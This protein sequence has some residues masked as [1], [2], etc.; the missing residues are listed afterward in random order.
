MELP[1]NTTI[2]ADMLKGAGRFT[3]RV[4]DWAT[5]RRW[6]DEAFDALERAGYR[7]GSAYTVVKD[8]ARTTFVYRDRLW[9]GADLAAIGVAS[10]GY[11]NGVHMQNVDSWDAYLSALDRGALP[12][13]RAYRPT[14]EERL[15]RELVLQLKR[16]S[17]RTDYFA[18]KYGVDVR[19][20]FAPAWASLEAEG[21]L[22]ATPN[23]RVS[24][25][26]AGLLRVDALL[27]RFFL[28]EHVGVRYT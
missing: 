16:G 24:L 3:E 19:T 26:R 20:R 5:R 21:Y 8:P 14:A 4:A 13:G 22:T 15:I 6:V 27:P 9:Q 1:Y 7:I 28:P 2:T 11:V 10:F 17:I 25:T 12:L 23:G 18:D